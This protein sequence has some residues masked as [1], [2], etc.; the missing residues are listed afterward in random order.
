M[1]DAYG[2]DGGDGI[3]LNYGSNAFL[4]DDALVRGVGG[5]AGNGPESYGGE[6]GNALS[7]DAGS[8]ATY[9]PGPSRHFV[10]ATPVRGNTPANLILTGVPGEQVQLL[11][12]RK[13]GHHFDL[14]EKGVVLLGSRIRTLSIGVVPASGTL[15][16]Q[17]PVPSLDPGF[18]STVLH[19][20]ARFIDAQGNAVLSGPNSMVVLSHLF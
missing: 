19:M 12:S 4:L 17:I 20:Q 2:G 16:T 6:D 15:S 5:G 18:E 1:S 9:L 10:L 13:A 14:T 11:M 3:R 7:T 8:T